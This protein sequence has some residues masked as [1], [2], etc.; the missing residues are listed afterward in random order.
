MEFK[1]ILARRASEAGFVLGPEQLDRFA[2]YYE[3]LLETNAVMN[4]TAITDAEGVAVKHIVDSL[5]AFEPGMEGCRLADVGSGAGFPGLPLKIYCPGL[6]TVLIDSIG[7]RVR[8]LEKVAAALGLDGIA[9][10][11]GRAEE[12]GRQ[13]GQREAYDFV[14]ARAVAKLASLAEYCLPLV[15]VGGTFLA[16]KGSNY[17]TELE[18]AGPAIAI[19]GG[20]LLKVRELQLPGSGEGRALIK[21]E[22][23]KK[24]PAAYPR[25][26]GAAKRPLGRRED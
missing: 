1:E 10:I 2:L 3:L 16:L 13:K 18:E 12:L 5:L 14:T 4:L 6:K 21:I 15:K 24:T 26:G 25:K 9:V 17:R 8:F 20:R 7:K 22:K 23:S 19:L 11:N